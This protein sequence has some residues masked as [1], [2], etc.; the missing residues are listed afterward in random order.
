MGKDRALRLRALERPFAKMQRL[1]Q[2]KSCLAQMVVSICDWLMAVAG[3]LT[4]RRSFH[5][6]PP[7]FED[8]CSLCLWHLHSK[9]RRLEALR[10]QILLR[11]L[12][13]LRHRWDRVLQSQGDCLLTDR[14]GSECVGRR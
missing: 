11:H 6:T 5:M 13:D 2:L 4:T 7:W 9:Q 3:P 1:Q 12:E 14:L 10:H 8:F